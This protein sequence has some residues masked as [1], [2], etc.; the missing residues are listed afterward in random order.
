M[1]KASQQKS[2]PRRLLLDNLGY[3][4]F[5]I[6]CS[7]VFFYSFRG[8][9]MGTRTVSTDII[10]INE[11]PTEDFILVSQ[12][13]SQVAMK[14]EGPMSVLKTIRGEDV[15]PVVIPITD[16]R[17]KVFTFD[18]DVIDTLPK[19]V[20]VVKFYPDS[21]PMRFERR[22]EKKI[23]VEAPVEGSPAP[24]RLLKLPLTVVPDKVLVRG[25]E[26]SL[27]KIETW[28]TQPIYVDT[29]APGVHELRVN[30]LPPKIPYV[31]PDEED[32]TVKVEI[33]YKMMERWFKSVPLSIEGMESSKGALLKPGKTSVHLSGPE[34]FIKTLSE[35]NLYFFVH[36]SEEERQTGGTYQK[37]ILYSSL[38]D[39]TV[40]TKITPSKITVVIKPPE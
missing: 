11:A 35:D 5:A 18:E 17:S 20:H 38:P 34:E 37:E 16:F 3:K 4:V 13:P 31:T 33:M 39:L 29:L 23:P 1:V 9:R 8:E 14:I 6:I 15:G 25:A 30:L 27:K 40:P 36:V 24:G 2:L 10:A 21:I 26:S 7:L 32:V 28:Q 22:V 19:T 12:F